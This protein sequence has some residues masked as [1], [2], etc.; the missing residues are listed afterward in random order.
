MLVNPQAWNEIAKYNGLKNPNVIFPGQKLNI[1]LRFLKFQPADG[2]VISAEGDVLLGDTPMQVGAAVTN[3]SKLRT[4]PNSSAVIE[5]ADGSRV[6]LLPNSLAEIVSSRNYAMRDASQSG[7][8]TWFS[9]LLRHSLPKPHSALPHC[10]SKRQR[11]WWACV[12]PHFALPLTIQRA[13]TRA[14]K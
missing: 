2:K 14:P 10:K 12:V 1:P 6:K 3:G 11:R 8:T 5:L 9:G 7:S 4:G 13:K